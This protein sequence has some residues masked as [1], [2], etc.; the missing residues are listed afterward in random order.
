[1]GW[2]AKFAA[3]KFSGYALIALILAL[4]GSGIWFWTELKEYGSLTEKAANLED[5]LSEKQAE[6]EYLNDSIQRKQK[7]LTAQQKRTDELE[8]DADKLR[9]AI[10]EA[11]KDA[12]QSYIDARNH[13]VPERLRFGA[14]REDS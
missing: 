10:D 12:P 9:Q 7:A 3:S 14:S 1:M 6:L 8:R 4:L 13:V 2:I 5:D 11:L